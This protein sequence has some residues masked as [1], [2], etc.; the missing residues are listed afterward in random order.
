[1]PLPDELSPDQDFLTQV[2]HD[3]I[4]HGVVVSSGTGASP[5]GAVTM[6]AGDNASTPSGWLVCDGSAV[7]RSTYDALF[8]VI[9][10]TYGAGDGSSTF[11]LPDMRARFPVMENGGINYNLADTG[12]ADSVTLTTAQMPGHSHTGSSGSDSH[13]HSVSQ[14][15][16]DHN[17]SEEGLQYGG[18]GLAAGSDYSHAQGLTQ[19]T[20]NWAH[21]HGVSVG[22]DSHAHAISVG[23][24]GGSGAHENR[25]PFLALGFIIKS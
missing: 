11:N 16:R 18:V 14:T 22:S 24:T 1:M 23:S 19:N 3:K 17:H 13:S 8:A 2:T 9:G 25:P 12:G 15:I 10:T 20:G 6:W 5:V 4:D 21:D 7:S